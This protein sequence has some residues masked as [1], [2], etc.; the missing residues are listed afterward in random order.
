MA[1]YELDIIDY[2]LIVKKRKYLI[3]LA[4]LL[5]TLFTFGFTEALKPIPIYEAAARVKFDRST[6]V[7]QQLIESLS[8]SQ[9]NDLSTQTE[10]IRSFPVMERVAQEFTLVE[11]EPSPE[12]RRSAAYLHTVYN[13]SQQIR[14]E[15]EADTSIIR[16][17]ANSND[18]PEAEKMANAVAQAYRVEN[19]AARNRLVMESRRF[20][21]EQLANLEEKLSAAEDA[22]RNFKEREGQVFLDEEAK[23]ALEMFSKLESDLDLVSRLKHETLQQIQSLKR[24]DPS[25]PVQRIFTE[26]GT[27]LL[28]VLN[29]K[30]LDLY[31]ER[32]TLL[33]NY[34]SEHPT[35]HEVDRKIANVKAEIER[36]LKSKVATLEGR[37]RGIEEQINRYRGRYLA[38]P[39]SAIR[40]ARLEREVKVNS[41]LY[42]TLKIKHQELQ[43]KSAEQIE[44]VTV[45]TPAITPSSPINA[46]NTEMNLVVGSLMGLFLGVVLAFARESFDTS[47]G[48]IEGVE[49]FLKVPVLGVIP[50]FDNEELVEAAAAVLPP[51][52]PPDMVENFSKLICL[53]DPKS[54]L[55][56]SLRSLRTNIQFASMDRKLKSLVFTSAGL[57]EGKSTVVVNLAVTLALE[58]Q[59]VLLVDADLRRPIVHQRLGLDREPGLVDTLVGGMSWRNSVRS[60]TDL[61]LGQMGVDRVLDTPGLDNL[62]ILTSGSATGNPSEFM[63]LNR[64][65]ALIAEMQEDY[66][67]V[68]FDTPPILPVTDAVAI[69]SRVDGTVLVYQ[70]GRIGRNA[71]KRAKFLLDHAQANTLGVVLTNVRA[72]ITPEAGMYR[73]EYK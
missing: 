36:E 12:V 54:V 25:T 15:R 70:V 51:Q 22:L 32:S 18:P 44:E 30:L 29:S 42:A 41:D 43:I 39:K 66:D 61:M 9:G 73:Y 1:Q 28:G 63:N 56:E 16:I 40:L 48:T 26:E 13:L 67:M 24:P 14:T 5:V 57:G 10:F 34:T 21:E 35:V 69:S 6:T 23:T 8:V 72:E 46:P 33:I 53:V 31:H 58:G 17:I 45:I 52:T 20:V 71:L 11:S 59:R 19:I 50:Q 4:A 55:S 60:V 3:G 62:F 27:S 7:A 38:F 64:I 65:K 47:I 37:E 2:W 68:L 49:E